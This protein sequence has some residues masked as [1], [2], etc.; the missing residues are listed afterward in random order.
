ME[1]SNNFVDENVFLKTES[2]K[3]NAVADYSDG[4]H[5]QNDETNK[6]NNN[7]NNNITNKNHIDNDI[8]D[9]SEDSDDDNASLNDPLVTS[10]E[11]HEIPETISQETKSQ[12][13]QGNE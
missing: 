2:G 3:T 5:F 7:N 12:S 13:S 1:N 4:N 6:S 11:D 9:Y 8:D 10:S